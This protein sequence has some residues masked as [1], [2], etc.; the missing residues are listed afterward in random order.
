MR[1][2]AEVAVAGV[3]EETA[4]AGEANAAAEA[5]AGAAK[6]IVAAQLAGE[7]AIR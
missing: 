6:R 5:E 3:A 4:I 7:G 2:A 1:V